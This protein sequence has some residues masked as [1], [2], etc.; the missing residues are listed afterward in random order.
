[1]KFLLALGMT[2]AAFAV[3]VIGFIAAYPLL[4]PTYSHR[5]RLTLEVETPD[6]LKKGSSVIEPS[7]RAQPP[8]LVNTPSVTDLNGDAVFV[9]LGKGENLIGLLTLGDKAQ[10]VDG[11]VHLAIDAFEVPHCGAPFCQ[12]KQIAKASGARQLPAKL[13]PTLATVGD[14][15][16]P[17]STRLLK[18][19]E[20]EAVFG[21]G[22]RFKRAWIELTNDPV[23]TGIER[24]L[25]FLES[26][27]RELTKFRVEKAG[28][29]F[30]PR[31][32]HFLAGDP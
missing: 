25:P 31:L 20:F 22:Y 32:G 21:P 8:I 14:V 19:D 13:Y 9:D 17:K 5:Y 16:D 26:H 30:V 23:S 7:A 6:G 1:M 24:K 15:T 12:W 10:D 27:K 11:P 18:P 29:P 4:Y 2:V 3:I 28:D